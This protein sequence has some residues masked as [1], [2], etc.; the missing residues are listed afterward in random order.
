MAV[1]DPETP[2][3]EVLLTY[4]STLAVLERHRL[5][6]C[7]GGARSVRVACERVGADPRTVLAELE[8]AAAAPPPAPIDDD[9]VSLMDH[10]VATHHRVT[11]E[12]LQTLPALARKVAT[13]HQSEAPYLRK[14]SEVVLEL[15]AEL[16]AHLQREERVLF[17]YVRELAEAAS[18]GRPA[19]R[20]TFQTAA[21][22]IH[23]MRSD[24][25]SAGALVEEIRQLTHGYT[26]PEGACTSWRALYQGLEAHTKD[27]MRHVWIENEVLFPKALA[28]E[29]SM[30]TRAD[31]AA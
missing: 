22:P 18:D 17:P 9:V 3:R 8:R 24:H 16:E 2:V 21:R 6:Y 1:L 15:F 30:R 31:N 20:P 5:D 26:V 29:S 28:L 11:S 27:L 23:V 10:V 7:C 14:L 25:E 4:P 13:V 12:A 19:P